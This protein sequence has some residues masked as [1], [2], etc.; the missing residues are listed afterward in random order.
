MILVLSALLVFFAL[1]TLVS[2]FVCYRLTLQ[3]PNDR[4][5]Y[6]KHSSIYWQSLYRK[7]AAEEANSS[8]IPEDRHT[9]Q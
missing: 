6:W 4:E 3:I 5:E 9:L 1:L 7:Q 8:D 2:I